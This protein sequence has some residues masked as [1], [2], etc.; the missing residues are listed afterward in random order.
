MPILISIIA[1]FQKPEKNYSKIIF[2]L[3]V[4]ALI[5]FVAGMVIATT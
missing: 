1:A 4:V 2:I 3:F 5:V